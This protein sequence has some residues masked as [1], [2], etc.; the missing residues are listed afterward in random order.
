MDS[1]KVAKVV[2]VVIIG[3]LVGLVVAG[4]L[5]KIS[6]TAVGAI[7]TCIL[8]GG[9]GFAIL[10]IMEARRSTNAQI[11]VSLFKELRGPEIIDKLRSIYLRKPE[12]FKDLTNS[13]GELIEKDIDYVIHRFEMLGAL[14][15]NGIID[16][17]LAIET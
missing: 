4:A 1:E 13:E 8:S 5:G 2:M 12:D 3:A 11:A 16:R 15:V 6:W 17:R 9:I 14:V 10:Q 7:A